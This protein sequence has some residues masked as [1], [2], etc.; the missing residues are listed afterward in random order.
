DD[1]PLEG[2]LWIPVADNVLQFYCTFFDLPGGEEGEGVILSELR[3]DGSG[4]LEE[5]EEWDKEDRYLPYAVKIV[6]ELDIREGND[7]LNDEMLDNGGRQAFSTVIRLP[8]FPRNLQY[9]EEEKTQ[10][11][12]R[13][14]P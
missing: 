12:L 1:L 3:L 6:L 9:I 5:L 7:K 4:D 14:P 8:P 10:L 13:T 2:G 11:S